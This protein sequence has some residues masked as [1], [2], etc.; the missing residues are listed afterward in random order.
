MTLR[1]VR[2][3]LLSLLGLLGRL[4]LSPDDARALVALLGLS[5]VTYGISQWSGPAAWV[6]GGFVACLP[7]A[8]AA[9][10]A[11]RVRPRR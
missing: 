2:G 6:T 9:V 5:A 11:V 4:R 3:R 8:R 7:F 1:V 10:L